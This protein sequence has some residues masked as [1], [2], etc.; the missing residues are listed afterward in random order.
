[1]AYHE[2]GSL[3]AAVEETL[4]EHLA[5]GKSLNQICKMEG[6]PNRA[7]VQRWQLDDA[8]FD[9][10]VTRARSIGFEILGDL[11][12]DEAV[13]CDD[14]AKGRLAFDARRWYL[15]KLS[16]AFSDKKTVDHQSTDGSMS[17]KGVTINANMSAKEAADI[18][19][20]ELGE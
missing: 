7:T 11:T 5:D 12:V 10:A 3:R 16:N 19:R 8:D 15:G 2:K 18:M 17:P 20:R 1:M 9:A 13:N 4:L 6:M 14:P